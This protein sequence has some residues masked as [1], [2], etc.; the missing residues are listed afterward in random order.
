MNLICRVFGHKLNRRRVRR[1]GG[2]YLGNCRRCK[3]HMKRTSDGWVA[4]DP[5]ENSNGTGTG[6]AFDN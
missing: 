4:S 3:A 2:S 5:D 1:I 6:L